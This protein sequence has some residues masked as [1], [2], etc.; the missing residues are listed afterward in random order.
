MFLSG[1]FSSGCV[2]VNSMGSPMEWVL[3]EFVS[4]DCIYRAIS[5]RNY[6]IEQ[7]L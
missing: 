4:S 6:E 7:S 5:R 2:L 1:C 3:L